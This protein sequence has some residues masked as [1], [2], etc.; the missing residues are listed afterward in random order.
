MTDTGQENRSHRR[1]G[2][3]S[4]TLRKRSKVTRACDACKSRKKA[5]SGD[6]PC[7]FCL[8]IGTSCTYNVPYHR[9]AAS[10]PRPATAQQGESTRATSQPQPT[11]QSDPLQPSP[12]ATASTADGSIE[13]GGQYR[14]PASAH[15]FLARAMRN[16][17]DHPLG[18]SQTSLAPTCEDAQGSIFSYG[19]RKAPRIDP[20]Q[21]IWPD[22][23]TVN[24]L[25][26]RYFEFA[27]PTYRILHQG[28]VEEWIGRLFSEEV[29]AS[30]RENVS[31]TVLPD[32]KAIILLICAL[33]SL[34]SASEESIEHQVS[35]GD[36]Q[37]CEAYYQMAEQILAK[38][39]GMPSLESVQARLLSVLYLLGASRMN[40]AWFNFGPT[41]QLLMAI[42]LHRKK[43]QS[44]SSPSSLVL[45]E[46]SKRVLWCSFT[47]DQY[48]SLILGRPRLLHEEDIDQEYPSLVNDENL[49]II[50]CSPHP[51]K[52]CLMD[53]TVCHSKLSRILARASQD[54]YSIKPI[55]RDQEIKSVRKLMSQIAQWQSELPPIFTD[56]VCPSSLITVFR[57]QSTVIR[58]ARFHAVMFVTRPLLLWDCS[59]E[60][61]SAELIQFLQ[62]C[63]TTARDTL[64]VVLDLVKDNQLFRA[65]WYTQYI[66]F[67]A[68][69][70]IYI[71]L[72][73]SNKRRIP[74]SWLFS[75][76]SSTTDAETPTVEQMQLYKLAERTQHYLGQ[77]TERNA[78]AW[79]YTLVLEVLKSEYK[80]QPHHEPGGEEYQLTNRQ[81]QAPEYSALSQSHSLG[82][83]FPV[84]GFMS[85]QGP[86]DWETLQASILD[87]EANNDF[88]GRTSLYTGIGNLF[89]ILNPTD[90][91]SLDFWPQ[92]D[93]LPICKL[94]QLVV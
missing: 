74:H 60:P 19:D 81:D 54:L 72:I 7:K 15:S 88:Q 46:C 90:D 47:L 68:L 43:T 36:M 83:E 55:E 25:V 86:V 8:R 41:V 16:F 4:R 2:L 62:S 92:L 76:G 37:Q 70:I 53:A 93:R 85:G 87:P 22:R 28:V 73:H 51:L 31:S 3:S 1:R 6:I 30:A 48:L 65:F 50:Q 35:P 39:T 52:N 91:F 13:I 79:R 80:S 89:P 5:C 59:H 18:T 40:Q 12:A 49:N 14:G 63:V 77:A 71:Y 56:T 9:G 34:S 29:V 78:L 26:Q 64:E 42:G 17:H 23:M 57:R 66:A 61:D 27:S 10:S 32:S 33:A 11:P 82:G 38:S 44:S 94:H 20:S 69:S 67:N 21:M 58:L 75:P 84:D 45:H 24:N